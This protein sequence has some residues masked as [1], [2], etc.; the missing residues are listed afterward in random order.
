MDSQVHSRELLS[1]ISE[2]VEVPSEDS[3]NEYTN[4]ARVLNYEGEGNDDNQKSSKKKRGEM[5]LD[6]E[7]VTHYGADKN[8]TH[9]SSWFMNDVVCHHPKLCPLPKEISCDVCNRLTFS[10]ELRGVPIRPLQWF[11]QTKD[12]AAI[13]LCENKFVRI[14]TEIFQHMRKHEVSLRLISRRMILDD[15]VYRFRGYKNLNDKGMD[16]IDVV[17]QHHHFR[18]LD[19]WC[20][21]KEHFDDAV[22]QKW[23][24]QKDNGLFCTGC[25]KRAL[26]SI[27]KKGVCYEKCA[28]DDCA[29]YCKAFSKFAR[30]YK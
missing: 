15:L 11:F 10:M 6:E 24:E 22:S 18:N 13:R 27:S 30:V 20:R 3:D 4:V 28:K 12:D 19:S 17:L 5:N 8:V 23:K 7:I 26:K 1:N 16:N 29:F 9:F 14:R 21:W 2:D 25:G